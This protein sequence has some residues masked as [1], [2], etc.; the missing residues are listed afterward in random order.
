MY[1]NENLDKHPVDFWAQY[2]TFLVKSVAFAA[3]VSFHLGHYEGQALFFSLA[4]G[5]VTIIEVPQLSATSDVTW[6]SHKRV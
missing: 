4:H 5:L 6:V 3:F 1:G 2:C